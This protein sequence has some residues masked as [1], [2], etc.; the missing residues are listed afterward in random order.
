MTESEWLACEDPAVMLEWLPRHNV[1]PS[2]RKLRLF[3]CA[4]CRQVWPLLTDERSQAAV[5]AAEQYADGLITEDAARAA[6]QRE[7]AAL[8]REIIGNP[9]RPVE[10]DRCCGLRNQG[11][12]IKIAYRIYSE[13]DFAAMPILADALEDA[14]CDNEEILRHCRGWERC[15]NCDGNGQ[16]IPYSRCG[17]CHSTG[18]MPLR[19]PHVRGCWVLDLLLGKE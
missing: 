9:F 17:F 19:G 4:C 15:S 8:L 3:A 7:Q 14:G 5:V 2:E 11:L 10:Y 1:P 6:E 12:V 16:A 18:W 13:R